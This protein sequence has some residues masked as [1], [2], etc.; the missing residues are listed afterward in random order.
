VQRAKRQSESQSL[1]LGVGDGQYLNTKDL[2]AA[3]DE[4]RNILNQL[5]A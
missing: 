2:S 5:A 1:S 4:V 3:K